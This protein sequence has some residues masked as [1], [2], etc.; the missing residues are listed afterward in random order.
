MKQFYQYFHI[1]ICF[2]QSIRNIAYQR[3]LAFGYALLIAGKP[4]FFLENMK[5]AVF[6]WRITFESY[7]CK[8]K[9]AVTIY[10]M[11]HKTW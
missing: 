1:Q 9:N 5:N 11:P 4:V 2:I 8:N 10:N 3:C 7:L 6:E